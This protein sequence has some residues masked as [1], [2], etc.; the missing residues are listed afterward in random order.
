MCST[1]GRRLF[2]ACGRHAIAALPARHRSSGAHPKRLLL[3][4][5][6]RTGLSKQFAKAMQ[7]GAMEAAHQL[8]AGPADF[9]LQWRAAADAT[10]Q[11]VLDADGYLFC[12]PENLASLSGE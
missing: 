7:R 4:W 8:E 6:S 3:V 2:P 9:E 5:H 12:A 11:D 10:W 1:L